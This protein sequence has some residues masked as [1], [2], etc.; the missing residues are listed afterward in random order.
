MLC[1][2]IRHIDQY[3]MTRSALDQRSVPASAAVPIPFNR[4]AGVL[5]WLLPPLGFGLFAI[6]LGQDAN[7]DLRNYHFYNAYAFLHGRLGFDIAPAQTPTYYNPLLHV[8][9]YYLV[10]TLP[11]RAVGFVLGAVQGLNL[12]LL[13]RISRPLIGVSQPCRATLIALAVA[14]LGCLGAANIS[15]LGTAF[16]D[17]LI[18]LG[19]LGA[20]W[21]LLSQRQQ[22]GGSPRRA[23]LIVAAA[24]LLAGLAVGLKQPTAV[25]ALGLG[26]AL[27]F[28]RLPWR[29]RVLLFCAFGAGG[30]IGLSV[31]GGYWL[32]QLWSHYGNPLFPY[33]NSVFHSPMA[34]LA[35][36]RDTRF[37]P[38]GWREWL[39]FPWVIALDPMHT[40]ENGF[41]DFRLP[42]LY[43]LLLMLLL[44]RLLARAGL[45]SRNGDAVMGLDTEAARLLLIFGL[46]SYLA[47]L[48]MF[49]IYRYLLP[50]ELLAP[51]GIWLALVYLWRDVTRALYTAALCAVLLLATLSPLNW[52]RVDWSDDYFGVQ[53]PPLPDPDHTMIL[54]A[55]HEPTAY[56]IPFFPPQIRFLRIQ[57]YFTGPSAQPNGSD[58]L[59]QRLVAG[60][61]G[62]L[63]ILYR[64]IEQG[65]ADDAVR[66]FG[67]RRQ[68]QQC[69][70]MHPH[71]EAAINDSIYICKLVRR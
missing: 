35:D 64:G 15:E 16:G 36:Y 68:A 28:L 59:M 23:G 66:A 26:F 53:P 14:A 71:I 1:P 61:A 41:R 52:G 40:A 43:G 22:L 6:F 25:F 19:V 21:W 44:R 29:R 48:K 4:F 18:S 46:V 57:S 60:H 38:Q 47:W 63:Y 11:P 20:L 12:P 50:L 17:N 24:G 32:Y 70:A 42:L 67:L 30:V 69:T 2:V 8:P 33:F 5:L 39:F 58:R 65:T 51:F 49:A 55:G 54:M 9:F 31:T 34:S 45:R 7:W 62:P 56:V 3:L 27:L 13:Y 10:T 37:L